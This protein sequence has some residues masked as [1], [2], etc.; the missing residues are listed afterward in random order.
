MRTQGVVTAVYGTTYV[1]QDGSGPWSGLWVAGTPVPAPGD[2]VDVQGVV[3]ET[4]GSGFDGTTFLS[5]AAVLSSV[6]RERCPR[7]VAAHHG[8]RLRR[9]L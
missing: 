8:H 5:G 9:G 2:S 3:T 1:I 7:P 6:A 4:F